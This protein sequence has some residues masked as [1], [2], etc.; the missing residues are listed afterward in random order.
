MAEKITRRIKTN[1]RQEQEMTPEEFERRYKIC[2]KQIKN[3]FARMTI[4]FGLTAYPVVSLPTISGPMDI[5]GEIKY[6]ISTPEE[7]KSAQT[8]L[9]EVDARKKKEKSSKVI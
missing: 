8:L 7:V 2:N 6:D 9:D 3:F 4:N 5:I 1:I